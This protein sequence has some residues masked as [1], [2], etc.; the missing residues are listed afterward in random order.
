MDF[1]GGLPTTRKRYDNLFVVVERFNKT[2][3]IMPCKK[4]IKGHEATQFLF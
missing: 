2:S 4:A 3:I 1:V